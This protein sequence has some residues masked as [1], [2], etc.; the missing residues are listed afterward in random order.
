VKKISLLF[1]FLVA[2]NAM[3]AQNAAQPA[4]Q[5]TGYVDSAIIMQG[6]GEAIKATG[7]LQALNTKY[8]AQYDSMGKAYQAEAADYQK[9]VS[10]MKPE[11]QKEAATKLL[12][13]EKVI[14]Q[15][16][17]EKTAELQTKRDQLLNPVKEKILKAIEAIAKEEGMNFVFD[18]SGETILLYADASTD[19]TYKVLDKLKR[20]K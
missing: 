7:D 17:Q 6:F 12:A 11:Q 2:A 3:F 18:K 5:K 4:I 1:F 10:T 8:S 9:K 19:I 14:Q 16:Q 20:G 13:K 15:F